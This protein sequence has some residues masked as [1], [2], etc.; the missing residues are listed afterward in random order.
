MATFDQKAKISAGSAILFTLI[1]LPQAYNLSNNF[2]PTYN[3]NCPTNL[4]LIIHALLFFVITFL[5][6]GDPYE[7]TGTK[8][9]HSL[10]GTLIFFLVSNPA[11]FSLMGSIFG[12]G[13]SNAIGCPSLTG[14]LLH[15]VVYFLA[16]VAVM[17]LPN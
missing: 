8:L 1:N 12:S 10:Y 14:I 9:K 5:T 2:L 3:I 17:Y 15:A 6:M 4:G 7:R 11:M 16:L 13:I